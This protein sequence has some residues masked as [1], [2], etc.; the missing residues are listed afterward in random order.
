MREILFRGKP[1]DGKWV[2]GDLLMYA[3]TAQIWETTDNGKFNCLVEP[4]SVGQYTGLLDK[5]GRKIFE[6]DIVKYDNRLHKVVYENRNGCAYFGI[7]IS[8]LDT[9]GFTYSVPC[10]KM[11]VV[12]NIY[13]NPELIKSR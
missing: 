11:E 9:W 6:G 2:Y 7:V 5:N 3:D 10:K 1:T 8:E 4:E 13:D 12:G